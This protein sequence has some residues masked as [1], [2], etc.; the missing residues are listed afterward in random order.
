LTPPPSCP[1]E[2]SP[3]NTDVLESPRLLLVSPDPDSR[4]LHPTTTASVDKSDNNNNDDDD[5]KSCDSHMI[6]DD[7]EILRPRPHVSTVNSHIFTNI[8]HSF[9][10]DTK[11]IRSKITEEEITKVRKRLEEVHCYGYKAVA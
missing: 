5:I 6:S 3:V 10:K 11:S 8:L 1:A 4:D 2:I 9:F 7:K